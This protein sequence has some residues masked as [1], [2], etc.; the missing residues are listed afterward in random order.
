MKKVISMVLSVFLLI[1][2]V[3]SFSLTSALVPPP[4]N[5]GFYCSQDVH[6]DVPYY[7]ASKDYYSGPAAAMQAVYY[8][9]QSSPLIPSF[10]QWTYAIGMGTD[11]TTGTSSSAMLSTLNGKQS[12]V[13][14]SAV[15][16]PSLEAFVDYVDHSLVNNVPV[17]IKT[18]FKE[19][20]VPTYETQSH[21][22]CITGQTNMGGMVMFVEYDVTDPMYSY[23][24]PS[25]TGNGKF[26][27]AEDIYDD[28]MADPDQTLYCLK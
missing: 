11:S 15:K 10:T 23:L 20:E 12:Q 18:A 25:G 19:G 17:V 13:A 1:G 5:S 7:A 24:Y 16:S 28:M 4:P 2:A 21:Y 27:V 14:Y 9:N 6:L 3:G 26:L 8:I 22:L